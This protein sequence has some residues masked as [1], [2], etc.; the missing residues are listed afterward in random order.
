M[1]R[2]GSNAT[3]GFFGK[4]FFETPLNFLPGQTVNGGYGGFGPGQ[5]GQ[6]ALAYQ[7]TGQ[8]LAADR[9]L[10]SSASR[11]LG[12]LLYTT[13]SGGSP[14]QVTAQN[15]A[16]SNAQAFATAYGNLLAAENALAATGYG[17][18]GAAQAG[19]SNPYGGN[20]PSQ[21]GGLLGGLF[22]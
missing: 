21:G 17:A 6:A 1:S 18:Y 14:Y 13:Y 4:Q 9:L 8:N 7:F 11:N 5:R 22:G 10:T 19:A 3:G 2:R 12:Q 15:M 16:A 20:Y